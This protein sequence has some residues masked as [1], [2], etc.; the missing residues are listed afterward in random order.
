MRTKKRPTV[1]APDLTKAWSAFFEDVAV[2][3]SAEL[4]KQGWMTNAEIAQ[5]SKL[6]GEAGRQLAEIAFRRGV[7]EKKVAKIMVSGRRKNVNFYRP[8]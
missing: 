6:E 7:L 3:D 2:T 8:K 4:K 1:A 5:Q